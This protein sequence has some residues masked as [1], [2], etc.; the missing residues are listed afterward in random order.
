[1]NVGMAAG[2]YAAVIVDRIE[3][4]AGQH[5][6]VSREV[7]IAIQAAIEDDDLFDGEQLVSLGQD[8]P[9]VRTHSTGN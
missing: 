1:M 8:L 7:L 3:H 6:D 9:V 2:D 4:A 5:H